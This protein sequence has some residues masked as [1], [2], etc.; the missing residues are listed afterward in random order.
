MMVGCLLIHRLTITTA[1]LAPP[2]PPTPPPLRIS[3]CQI[4]KKYPLLLSDIFKTP[5][6]SPQILNQLVGLISL[7]RP[8]CI[9]SQY[10]VCTPDT[11][12]IVCVG[13]HYY[14]Y[15][16][17]SIPPPPPICPYYPAA[18]P[19]VIALLILSTQIANFKSLYSSHC[20][21]TENDSHYQPIPMV[22]I[23]AQQ[24]QY[25]SSPHLNMSTNTS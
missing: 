4:L 21:T 2:Q 9:Y 8:L 14:L 20:Y 13:L 3:T 23:S 10:S 17:L 18:Q 6:F 11:L 5:L 12:C 15:T 16:D 1:S 22:A 25:S 19:R 24:P 7:P